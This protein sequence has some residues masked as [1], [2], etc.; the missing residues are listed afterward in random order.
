MTRI[1]WRNLL[2]I[3]AMDPRMWMAVCGI[4]AAAGLLAAVGPALRAIRVDPMTVLR[5]E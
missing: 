4:L 2:V 5:S 3:S 1:V